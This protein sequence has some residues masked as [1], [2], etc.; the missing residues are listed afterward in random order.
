[1]FSL[2]HV[3]YAFYIHIYFQHVLF[4]YRLF[5]HF[6]SIRFRIPKLLEMQSPSI[7]RISAET[8]NSGNVNNRKLTCRKWKVSETDSEAEFLLWLNRDI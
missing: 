3:I 4:Y 6:R 8:M 2:F 1:M 7:A 5:F